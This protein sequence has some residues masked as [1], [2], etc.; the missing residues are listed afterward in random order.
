M[1]LKD[2]LNQ[3]L[4]RYESIPFWSWNDELEPDELRRQIRAMKKAGIGGFFMHARGGLTTEYLGEKWFEA[5][6]ACID[7]AKKQGMDAWC[8]DENG[9]PSG[10]AGMKL[11]EDPANWVHYVTCEKKNA[12]DESAL[13]VYV[14]DGEKL[15]RV[16]ENTGAKEYIALYD[17]TNSSVVDILNPEIVK[18][19]LNE[20]HEKYFARFGADFGKAMKGFFTDEPQ[21]FRWDTAYT[22]VILKAYAERYGC[23]LLDVLG[24]LF[25]DCEGAKAVRH[26]YWK[27]MNELYTINFAKQIHDWCE[28]HNCQLTGHTIQENDLFGQMICSAGVMPFYKYEHKPGVD[29]LGR[30][31]SV[32]LCPRQCSSVA[33]QYGKNQVLTETFACAGWDVTPRELKRIAEW[34]YVNGVNQMCQHLYPYSIRGQRKRDYPAFYSEHNS[35]TKGED[36]KRFND[37]FTALGYMLAESEEIAPVAVIHPMHSAYLTF[38]RN[39]PHSVDKLNGKFFELIETLGRANIGHHYIDETLFAEDGRVDGAKLIMGKCAYSAVVVPEMESLDANTAKALE[40]FVQNGGKLYLQGKAPSMIDGAPAEMPFLKSNVALEDLVSDAYSIDAPGTDVHST[41]RAAAFGKFLFAV[42]LSEEAAYRV[43]YRFKA[44][45]AK[46]F[47]LETREFEPIHFA[48]EGESI[49]VPL[50]FAPGESTVIFLDDVAKSAD[51]PAEKT[52]W[53]QLDLSAEIVSADENTFTLD[54]V[55]ISYDGEKYSEMLPVMAAS[56][57]LLRGKTNRKVWLKYAFEVREKPES[58][59][60]ECEDMGQTAVMLNGEKLELGKGDTFDPAF[61][62]ADVLKK[63]RVGNNELVFEIYYYQPQ[64]VYDVFNGVYYEHSDGTESLINCLSYRTNI[65]AVYLRGDFG[66]HT[67]GFTPDKRNTLVAKPE[68]AIERAQKQ[69]RLNALPE[70]G[71]PFFGGSMTVKTKVHARGDETT[72]RLTGRYMLAK[73]RINGGE[74]RTIMFGD[75]ADVSG[76]LHAGENDVEIALIFGYRNVFGP[77]HHAPEVEPMWVSPDLFAGYGHWDENGKSELYTPNYGF[78]WFGLAGAELA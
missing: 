61:L 36:F 31:T 3:D 16:R 67:T 65:E 40:T 44:H 11:L 20:T 28:A 70:S 37:Y 48:T 32:E 63:V 74:T 49:V 19:F 58:L 45:G 21:Y 69:V 17:R 22:P 6:D 4:T 56:D 24:A 55:A 5:T 26:H 27:L 8:Y 75:T 1:N 43:S 33:Q 51:A 72:L 66:V 50:A 2:C 73:V 78:T 30:P 25:V 46:R 14:M 68:F 47:N 77:F 35:W 60:V 12:F 71:Y 54:T 13:A 15:V 42:N 34:Q 52:N 64:L 9:W 38:K 53:A 29:W 57:R 18:K 76:M 62:T 41:M 59:R 39:D 10:F 23:D 7:E